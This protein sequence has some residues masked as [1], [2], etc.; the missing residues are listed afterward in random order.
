M[1]AASPDGGSES[2]LAPVP[3]S[4]ALMVSVPGWD[5]GP[6]LT[7]LYEGHYRSLVRLAVLLVGDVAAAEE[8]V[9]DSFVAVHDRRR[10]LH[11]SD[12]ALAYLRRCVVTGSRTARRHRG[13]R[14]AAAPA[15]V[16]PGQPGPGQPGPGHEAAALAGSPVVAALRTL[17][18]R[19]REAL[20]LRFYGDLTEDVAAAAMGTSASAVR[21]HTDRGM[22]ALRG[23]LEGGT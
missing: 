1:T 7:Q 2:S 23:V 3:A 4:G 19:E 14:R 16:R 12:Q 21:G 9:Q 11:D 6:G 13:P 10:R 5:A 15:A 17:P 18:P 20:V 22:L 8:I